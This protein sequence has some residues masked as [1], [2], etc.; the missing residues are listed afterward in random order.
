M[1]EIIN[2]GKQ[3]LN[4]ENKI[5]ITGYIDNYNIFNIDIIKQ[6]KI[7]NFDLY[8]YII[9]KKINTSG[10]FMKWHIDDCAFIKHSKKNNLFN[11]KINNKL[12][13]YYKNKIPKYSLIIYESKYNTDFTGGKLKFI[14]G[15]EIKPDIGLY[16]LFNSIHMH[17]VEKINSGSRICYLI[18]FYDKD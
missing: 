14:D 5:I 18:K 6:L 9:C 13:I 1:N 12:S 8:D 3:L 7:I 2:Y 11:N 16:V 4:N 17:C 10:F 15:T